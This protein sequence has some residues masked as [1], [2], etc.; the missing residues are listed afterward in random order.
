MRTDRKLP[1]CQRDA[2]CFV[3]H[4]QRH[5]PK[6]A[7]NEAERDTH[8]YATPTEQV[9]T[10]STG[11]F[12]TFPAD[13]AFLQQVLGRVH[14]LPDNPANK[15]PCVHEQGLRVL[16]LSSGRRGAHGRASHVCGKCEP[17]ADGERC[18]LACFA[19]RE[20]RYSGLGT[21]DNGIAKLLD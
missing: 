10:A 20:M 1:E 17:R 7:A 14:R 16:T 8:S 21:L 18:P 15:S 11:G 19:E 5:F 9:A 6:C 4:Q 13:D 3:L 2:S 12:N